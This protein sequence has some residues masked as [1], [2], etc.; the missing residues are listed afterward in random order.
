[1]SG[2]ERLISVSD[3]AKV[4]GRCDRQVRYLIARGRLKTAC[5]IGRDWLIDRSEPYPEDARIKSGKC[6]GW[7]K[8]IKNRQE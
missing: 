6:V 2:P 8:N 4:H 5:K 3:Y 1:M 7:R